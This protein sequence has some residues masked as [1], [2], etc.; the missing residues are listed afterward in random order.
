[1]KI[2]PPQ[3][4]VA[5]LCYGSQIVTAIDKH[6]GATQLILQAI[7]DHEG[8][9]KVE[10]IYLPET[11]DFNMIREDVQFRVWFSENEDDYCDNTYELWWLTLHK[12]PEPSLSNI[13]ETHYEVVAAIERIRQQDEDTWPD[14]FKFV[15]GTGGFW[16]LAKDI[17]LAF[18]KKNA[19]RQWDGEFFDE[20][21]AFI[22]EYIQ[23]L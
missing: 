2:H 11:F 6:D 5:M 21:E 20:I 10:P 4:C 14:F 1:M 3:G 8:A 23:N 16:E 7:Q 19:D 12:Q 18:E 13:L 9:K 22:N 17:T 15:D